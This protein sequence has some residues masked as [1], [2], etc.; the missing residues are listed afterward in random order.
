MLTRC[1]AVTDLKPAFPR[2]Y[3]ASTSL[4][5][6]I[7][8]D[9]GRICQE[10]QEL[11]TILD[12]GIFNRAPN[13]AHL[14]TYVVRQVFEGSAGTL[15]EYNI[16][17][18]ALGRTVVSIRKGTPSY[19]SRPTGCANASAS[20]TTP[21]ARITRC[22]STFP[23]AVCAEIRPAGVPGIESEPETLVSQEEVSQEVS[24]EAVSRQVASHDEASHDETRSIA[25]IVPASAASPAPIPAAVR[26]SRSALIPA[27][28]LLVFCTAA[29]ALW[30]GPLGKLS[31]A[32]SNSIVNSPAG[33]AGSEEVRILA[34]HVGAGYTDRLGRIWTGDRYFQGGTVYE[35]L[36]H[37]ISGTRE[38]RIYQSRREGAFSYDI[39]LPPGIYELRLHFAETL[40]GENNVAGGGES[41]RVFNVSI[42]G[43]DALREFDEIS[44]VGPST[45]DI[46]TFR[47]RRRRRQLHLKF[48]PFTNPP[49]VERD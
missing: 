26:G 9:V 23:R 32:G 29:L 15:K 33:R 22:E 21:M 47:S 20:I 12:S 8:A 31:K 48:E 13:L 44:E 2:V 5:V 25:M 49:G 30:N 37:P 36:D 1:E 10:K 16:A 40:Y 38:P 43:K 34:G 17:V 19:A 35:T 14:L 4:G 7:H 3:T 11:Q 6:D 27:A 28:A 46:R 24:Q 41:S 18:D 42:N 39:P 45:A